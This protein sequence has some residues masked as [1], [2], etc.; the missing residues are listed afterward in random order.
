[1]AKFADTMRLFK[2]VRKIAGC[3]E[4][5]KDETEVWDNKMADE[6]LHG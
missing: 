2:I 6:I 5:Q 4:L 1:M 3:R